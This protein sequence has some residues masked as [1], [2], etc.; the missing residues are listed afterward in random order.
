ME[1]MVSANP[2][3]CRRCSV[4]VT[5]NTGF[6]G[7]WLTLWLFRFGAMVHDYALEPPTV[8]NVFD[9]T[10]TKAVLASDGRADIADFARPRRALEMT[11]SEVVIHLAAPPL[12]RESLCDQLGA[13]ASNVAGAAHVL[14]AAR[15]TEF[16]HVHLLITTGKV[17]EN[18]EWMYAHREASRDLST[19]GNA[20]PDAGGDSTIGQVAKTAALLWGYAAR[21]GHCP[22]NEDVRE[23]RS[24]RLDR[25]RVRTEPGRK[26]R[27]S[28]RDALERTVRRY[29]A[30]TQGASMLDVSLNEIRA[31]RPAG[32]E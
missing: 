31:Y 15:A 26:S 18:R 12:V 24:L 30:W 22:A 1:D 3:P 14:E 20:G 16:G 28:Q 5:D 7:G 21:V 10:G 27:W 8:P 29:Q 17:N 9:V 32:L 2:T 25:T 6:G 13:L 23:A 19:A 4:L 11:Q